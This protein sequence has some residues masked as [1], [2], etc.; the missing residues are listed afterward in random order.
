MCPIFIRGIYRSQSRVGVYGGE[1][2]NGNPITT[3][4]EDKK[5][6]INVFIGIIISIIGT[7]IWGFGD[8]I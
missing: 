3:F 5:I 2:A 1:D 8:L 6:G 4:T 7:I